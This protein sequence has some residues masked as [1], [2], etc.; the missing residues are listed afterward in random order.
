MASTT[1][2]NDDDDELISTHETAP[3]IIQTQGASLPSEYARTRHS[4]C[5][6]FPGRWGEVTRIDLSACPTNSTPVSTVLNE[7]Y[8]STTSIDSEITC[9]DRIRNL[10]HRKKDIDKSHK[11]LG[12]WH[13]TA[14]A[15]ND[16]S[17]SCLYTAGICAQK[18]GQYSF[19]SLYL[20]A[21]VLYLFRNIYAEVGLALPLN[22]GAYN[23][24]LNCT[25]K[26]IASVAACL[27]LVSYIATAVV[28]ASSAIAYGQNLWSG[29]DPSW[30]VMALLGFF[31]LL[32]LL[33]LKES[34]NVALVIFAIHV[35]AMTL[36]LIMCLI[37]IMKSYDSITMFVENWQ[38]K[39]LSNVPESIFYGFALALLGV[40]G[41]ET[42][43][44]YIEEQNVGVFPK[45]LRNM[46]YVVSLFNP[47]FSLLSLFIMPLSVILQHRDDLLAA[48]GEATLQTGSS[49]WLP[50]L[51][52]A[53]ALLVLSGAVL[54][55]Y[56]GITGLIRRMSYDRCLPIF[57]SYTNRWRDTNHF[58]II[59]FFL[60]TSL[61]H[62]I[63]RGN[64]ES[65][66][67]VYSISFLSVMSLFAVGNMILK[68]KRSTLR[69]KIYASWPHV[70]LGFLLVLIGLIGEIT[71]NLIHIK[72]FLLYFGITF[73]IVMLM[74]SRNRVLKF[75][76]YFGGPKYWL[77]MLNRQYKKIEDR[78]MLFFTR[79]DDPSVLNKAILY[80][81]DNELTH[82]L[83]ICHVYEN[84]QQI[85]PMLEM[86]I[87]FL[88]R[89]YPKLC[90]DLILVKGR[91]DPPTV[92]LLSERLDIPTNFM[93]ITCPAGN[94][95]HHLA[96]MG[97]IRLITH[98]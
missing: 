13:A 46:W 38:T 76:I 80:V 55:S 27:T 33:G 54:T 66:A 94:F 29:L 47:L 30:A 86:N 20:V 53:D 28:S 39:P 31:C 81:R 40:S 42:S 98:S 91:F 45:T 7:V 14:I 23:V 24:L 43:S 50:K 32:T 22:G 34:A 41:F 52:S 77:E 62:F 89:Q 82:L 93:F 57:L 6:D 78:P 71:L 97:G 88:D 17:S 19:I 92:K 2:I 72:F 11:L 70:I 10:I 36:L 90:L 79:T 35:G 63:V 68:Y 1:L 26:L 75:F 21:F 49:L 5:W 59:G 67:G 12:E 87:R 65:L 37:K 96:E 73:F 58:I 48:M 74:F 44:N 18:A 56:V 3:L 84:E 25:S 95:S 16:I 15:G 61:L 8:V 85:P 60:V 83:K 4:A 64:L 51:I 9:K 69:R